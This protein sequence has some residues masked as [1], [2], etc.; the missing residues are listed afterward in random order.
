MVVE[1]FILKIKNMSQKK[2]LVIGLVALF[3]CN[4]SLSIKAQIITTVAGNG[5]QG[6]S[7]DGAIATSATMNSP[8]GG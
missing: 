8:R 5:A 6:F 4:A 7:G 2:L 1:S 3:S